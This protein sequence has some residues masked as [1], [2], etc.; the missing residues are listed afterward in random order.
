MI[1]AFA[2]HLYLH[3]L[4]DEIALL[5]KDASEKS[6]GAVSYGTKQQCDDILARIKHRLDKLD[7]ARDFADT[8]RQRARLIGERALFRSEDDAVPRA[9]TVATL[10]RVD[11][12]GKVSE[13]T[14]ADLLGHNYWKL[15]EIVSR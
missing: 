5:A 8:L 9:G 3:F 13:E 12:R 1:L 10:Y 2:Q 6:V 15:A 14:G 11:A 7:S 4:G